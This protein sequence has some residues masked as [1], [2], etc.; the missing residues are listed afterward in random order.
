MERPV[1][2]AMFQR[3][4]LQSVR[5]LSLRQERRAAALAGATAAGVVVLAMLL[6]MAIVGTLG[7]VVHLPTFLLSWLAAAAVV[8]AMAARRARTKAR[9]YE[10]G[11][12]IDAD[13]FGPSEVELVRRL[14]RN[15]DYDIGLVPGMTGT[16]DQGRAP[17]SIEGLLRQGAVRVPLPADGRV[18]IEFGSATFVIGRS[19]AVP[20]APMAWRERMTVVVAGARRFAP[21]AAKGIP[22]AALATLLGSVPK[23]MAV[24]EADMQSPIPLRATPWETEQHIRLQ[25]QRHSA[26]LHRCFDPLPLACQRPGYVAVGLELAKDGEVQS[27][28]VARSTYGNDCPVTECMAETVAGWFYESMP[29]RMKVVVPIQVKRTDRPLFDPR[30]VILAEPVVG[31]GGLGQVEVAAH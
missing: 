5:T 27:R 3:G 10:V 22:V 20:A 29:E 8:G 14:G 26:A 18:R 16:F 23:V 2:V 6:T 31:D 15:D 13:A 21:V 19:A 24:S 12:R 7:A 28:W 9:G 17:L 4:E 1:E 25:A 30:P 11:V